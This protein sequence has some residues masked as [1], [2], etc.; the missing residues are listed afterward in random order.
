MRKI[1]A[2][3]LVILMAI[4]FVPLRN[5]KQVEA[6]D[7]T[8]ATMVA[9]ALQE[10]SKLTTPPDTWE[11][12][13]STVVNVQ[14]YFQ[15]YWDPKIDDHP[16]FENVIPWLATDMYLTVIS[17]G[18]KSTLKDH[19]Y[20]VIATTFDGG[21]GTWAFIDPDTH[22]DLPYNKGGPSY[23]NTRAFRI[24]NYHTVRY[25]GAKG[26]TFHS[27]WA[28]MGNSGGLNPGDLFL[29]FELL[30]ASCCGN[31][32]I[33]DISVESD[34]E[35]VIWGN[36]LVQ[37]PLATAVLGPGTGS[38]FAP[39]T[40]ELARSTAYKV[41]TTTFFDIKLTN[42]EYLDL[43][44]FNDNGVDNESLADQ[45]PVPVQ[46]NLSDDY[47]WG[48]GEEY[49][50]AINGNGFTP[51]GYWLMWVNYGG[52]TGNVVYVDMD[53][54]NNVSAGDI[55]LSNFY[56]I[57]A[58]SLVAPNDA[59]VGAMPNFIW[60]LSGYWDFNLNG[61]YD[62]YV[63]VDGNGSFWAGVD[64]FPG[65]EN[66]LVGRTDSWNIENPVY[67]ITMNFGDFRGMDI[68]VLPGDMELD[69]KV[70]TEAG[71]TV[72]ELKV[73]QTYTVWVG[74]PDGCTL[75]Q[76][77]KVHVVLE[78]PGY[79]VNG[80]PGYEVVKYFTLDNNHRV[81]KTHNITP[82]RGS[83]FAD[84]STHFEPEFRV[85]AFAEICSALGPE[86]GYYD[87]IYVPELDNDQEN[88]WQEYR[89]DDQGL[90]LDLLAEDITS[91]VPFEN[92]FIDGEENLRKYG[93]YDCYFSKLY[94]INPEE[95][96][97]TPNKEC[98]SPLDQRWPN[99][100]FLVYNV[101]N[102]ADADDP[103]GYIK[104]Y[105][106]TDLFGFVNAKG[107]GIEWINIATIS[108]TDRYIIQYNSD[109]SIYVWTWNDD[110]DLVYERG[111]VVTQPKY[112]GPPWKW[113]DDEGTPTWLYDDNG[114]PSSGDTL[115]GT[116]TYKLLS[117]ALP[118]VIESNGMIYALVRAPVSGCS[119]IEFTVWTNNVLYNFV[120]PQPPYY[121]LDPDFDLIDYM[122]KVKITVTKLYDLNFAE[123]EIVDEGLRN[124][125]NTFGGFMTPWINPYPPYGPAVDQNPW[126]LQN[127]MMELRSYPGGQTLL[128]GSGFGN[129]YLGLP[130]SG[131]LSAFTVV[132]LH[133]GFNSR[134]AQFRDIFW[135][136]G[137]EY[138]PLTNYTI[139]FIAKDK[140]GN[141]IGFGT[142]L[143]SIVIEGVK[144][145]PNA[146]P[147]FVWRPYQ[148]VYNENLGAW[149]PKYD[150]AVPDGP[151]TY[152]GTTH[153]PK[154][155][156]TS[157]KITLTSGTYQYNGYLYDDGWPFKFDQVQV[158]TGII[159]T[160]PG[161]LK[162]TITD[163]AGNT[164]SFKWCTSCF[165]NPEGVPVHAV[166]LT[167]FPSSLVV[168][169]DNTMEITAKVY[170]FDEK[171]SPWGETTITTKQP[172]AN[173]VIMFVWQDRGVEDPVSK[174][175]YGV[176]D[177][178]ITGQTPKFGGFPID[179]LLLSPFNAGPVYNAYDWNGDGLISFKD[180]ETEIVGTY[181][182]ALQAWNGGFVTYSA[183]TNHINDGKY[184]FDLTSAN[185]AVLDEI[186]F[187]FD[188][189]GIILT[190]EVIP[191]R[192]TA[193]TYGDDGT[194]PRVATG[195]G[196]MGWEP[197]EV[198]LAGQVDI[199]VVG[200][201]DWNVE[202]EPCLTAGVLPEAQP[203]GKPLTFMV[204]DADGNPVNLSNG[205]GGKKVNDTMIWNG[206]FYDVVP[207][208]LPSYYW[209]RTDLHNNEY[210]VDPGT[211]LTHRLNATA[212][213][214]MYTKMPY[215]W[216]G[217][218]VA[219]V[220]A[221]N[222]SL[223][224]I[225]PDFSEKAD[226]IYKFMGFV[227]NDKGEFEVRVYSPDRKHYA[228][229]KVVVELPKISYDIVNI[230]DPNGTVHTVPGD[231]DFVM[232]AGDLRIYKVTV[233]VKDCEDKPIGGPGKP[234]E[235]CKP[236]EGGLYAGFLPYMGYTP[237][238]YNWVGDDFNGDGDVDFDEWAPFAA[239]ASGYANIRKATA[240]TGKV[241]G[242]KEWAHYLYYWGNSTLDGFMGQQGIF[243]SNYDI[244]PWAI[245]NMYPDVN[246]DGVIDVLDT[247]ALDENGQATFYV[248][249]DDISALSGIV[250]K[251][252]YVL[253]F[254]TKCG[255][256]DLG[257]VAGW[258][259]YLSYPRYR[260]GAWCNGNGN[261]ADWGFFLDWYGNVDKIVDVDFMKFKILNG[262]THQEL[263]KEIFNEKYYDLTY[264]LEN[265]IVVQ[266][267]P[268]DDRDLAVRE[269]VQVQLVGNVETWAYGTL[270]HN[271][272]G[273]AET[274]L[275]FLPRGV[276]SRVAYLGVVTRWGSDTF[277][278]HEYLYPWWTDFTSVGE[279]LYWTYDD[280]APDNT[281]SC[282]ESK[283]SIAGSY[284]FYVFNG[285][286]LGT[287]YGHDI[288]DQKK[289][290]R[291]NPPV[292]SSSWPLPY[293]DAGKGLALTL[294]GDLVVGVET[295]VTVKVTE[296]GP[297]FQVAGAEVTLYGAGVDLSG[298]TDADGV[299]K[300]MVK[301]TEAGEILITAMKDGYVPGKTVVVVGADTIAPELTVDKPV[302][303]TNKP[304]VTITGMATDNAGVPMVMV[305]GVEA[306]VGADGKF[307][308]EVTLKEGENEIVVVA[309]D[310]SGN[311]TEKMVKVVLDTIPPEVTV[312]PPAGP[313][314]STKVKLTGYVETGAKVMVN[315]KPAVVATDDW[316]VEL[317][318]DYGENLVTVV[319]TD[320]VGNEKKVETTVVVFKKTVLELQIGN[321]TPKVNGAYGDPLEAAPFIKDGR[322]MVPL[323]FI[324]EAFGANVEWIPE[325]KGINISLELK[326]AVH[327]IGLQVGNP[328][329]IVDGE[330]VTLDVAP[331][332]VNGRTFVP[333]R[334]VAEAFGATVDWN[335][336]YQ[337][338]TIN[339]LWY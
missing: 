237:H 265:H 156:Y 47:S 49:I 144:A 259:V 232:T 247:W 228:T 271:A 287:P 324:A 35:P 288:E 171:T 103:K 66:M 111:E 116:T 181:D 222:N 201:P 297:N 289:L 276:G 215:D 100:G 193:Y 313:L 40:Q 158:I 251:N 128:P 78:L 250:G 76:G 164:N 149:L 302:S 245:G 320:A 254:D 170:P 221:V 130:L 154:G 263:G 107:T 115:V 248:E 64:L 117:W 202:T 267:L 108:G 239:Y 4:S 137:T 319:A 8:P 74:L 160:G 246:Q 62:W 79:D 21:V 129:D 33:Y 28:D 272:D 183:M 182:S 46:N 41:S 67:E 219:E 17:E 172:L 227:A 312:I 151:Y 209:V 173:Q 252:P 140:E 220:D 9:N 2:I 61:N 207:S 177:A 165:D 57:P 93:N 231:P 339:F 157:G 194:N 294:K 296:A 114:I 20:I 226:G 65:L 77:A 279:P 235:E 308:A 60:E 295:E 236:E 91:V 146:Q 241:Y 6:Y 225:N 325:T 75:P 13:D 204:T 258:A 5:I 84:F 24:G 51:M 120:G 174:N 139:R 121:L 305:N 186:G 200:V 337:V 81:E 301:P 152:L 36:P 318:L 132:G 333:L 208:V 300:F 19:Y 14:R 168:D 122:G 178:W 233:T 190:N 127:Y 234:L 16:D 307:S 328:T 314:T 269:G 316:E 213:N 161:M 264:G 290:T 192:I 55:R 123:F 326:S 240:G 145:D 38:D 147:V 180:K 196:G 22:F 56:N 284:V 198:Y 286:Y 45:A 11:L 317:T 63:D 327:T 275:N 281:M 242:P 70:E 260:F 134:H 262:E 39:K 335:Q 293:F 304:T 299:A 44:I 142:G 82:W 3:L 162:I 124:F 104:S 42:R 31:E 332:I 206:L 143:Y 330:V 280:R 336:L 224:P 89:L 138:Y 73:E 101:D 303:P 189:N 102:P 37:D 210:V 85:R 211:G 52:A 113:V 69:V 199:P 334:F 72:D 18:S 27:G 175:R 34:V 15:F 282:F 179:L 283:F 229:K 118:S 243:N 131:P 315:N 218:G 197:W 153:L 87:L 256:Y 338:V 292:G 310:K 187:D 141:H 184:L 274:T 53:T 230:E 238:Y 244:G 29:F 106:E 166:E 48:V 323:R 71:V 273:V 150:Y 80:N 50:G 88:D 86:D 23:S 54:S 96:K 298:I 257:D 214:D 322:T 105:G 25:G 99:I 109:L 119:E 68:E 163:T 155:Y 148:L 311:K 277:W 278:Q 26:R 159:P 266:A 285:C 203:D 306:T 90:T 191:V 212:A 30:K 59:D 133:N 136:L 329:A 217:D 83:L 10:V 205:V 223:E 176:G 32:V 167:N 268:A 125:E 309:K 188:K 216:D 291:L 43:E 270:M 195:T 92:Y 97:L 261:G 94:P 321:P 126:V 169:K 12:V 1:L 135:K 7:K 185:G 255:D 58:P 253:I 249:V 331:V 98:I 110:G 112:Y 95:L